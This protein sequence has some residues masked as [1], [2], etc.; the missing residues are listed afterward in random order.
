MS[1][2]TTASN[3][4]QFREVHQSLDQVFSQSLSTIAIQ[5][6]IYADFITIFAKFAKKLTTLSHKIN[7]QILANRISNI[8]T[9]TATK[10]LSTLIKCLVIVYYEWLNVRGR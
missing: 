9:Q 7:E 10:L 1:Q 3:I 5:K 8:K 6:E 4:E 2:G